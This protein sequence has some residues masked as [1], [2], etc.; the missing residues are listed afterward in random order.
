[1]PLD[2]TACIIYLHEETYRKSDCLPSSFKIPLCIDLYLYRHP[3]SRTRTWIFFYLS[4]LL[5]IIFYLLKIFPY[6]SSFTGRVFFYYIRLVNFGLTFWVIF[7]T[8]RNNIG[9]SVCPDRRDNN[10]VTV[11]YHASICKELR[12]CLWVQMIS[13]NLF[14]HDEFDDPALFFPLRQSR[15]ICRVSSLGTLPANLLRMILVLWIW[16][17]TL[18]LCCFAMI[19]G[20]KDICAPFVFLLHLLYI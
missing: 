4:I 5:I 3:Y 19:Y 13:L 1:M 2:T 18:A 16:D 7:L 20:A 6:S 15:S 11:I 8:R 12:S 9:S 17:I 10:S 14:W